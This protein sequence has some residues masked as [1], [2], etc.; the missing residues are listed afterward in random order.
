MNGTLGIDLGG[1]NLKAIWLAPGG[2]VSRRETV[3]TGET[4]AAWKHSIAAL[5][6]GCEAIGLAAPGLAD[7]S[8]TRIAHMPG[9]FQGLESLDWPAELQ[10][11]VH[12]LNDAHAALLGEVA[13]GAARGFEHVVLL[14]L[15]TGV[16]GAVL[17]GG[18]LLRGKI[19]RAGHLGHISLDFHGAPDITGTPGSLEDLIGDCTVRQR[20]GFLTTEELV[21]AVNADDTIATAAWE[22]SV[23]ALAAGIASL[24]NAFDPE[25]VLLGGGIT[26]AGAT[27]TV[28]LDR[29]LDRME[30]RPGGQRVPIRLAA[31]GPWAGA[32]GA[33]VA[34]QQPKFLHNS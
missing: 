2:E 24:I 20:T 19:G 33:A 9:R 8:G 16:G 10:R 17:A 6:K 34:V 29:H 13:H 26:G 14:T 25:I 32:I 31:L 30:W 18:R 15:G 1:R 4:A 28:P 11:P 3:P 5:A 12:V 23:Q 22:T 21:H 27:L 7:A